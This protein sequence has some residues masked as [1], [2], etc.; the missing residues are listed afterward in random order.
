MEKQYKNQTS[1]GNY[2]INSYQRKHR[3]KGMTTMKKK[4]ERRS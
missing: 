1:K 4:E 3:S 2:N